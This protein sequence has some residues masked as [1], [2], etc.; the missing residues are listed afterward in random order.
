MA[1]PKSR[2]GCIVTHVIEGPTCEDAN[3]CFRLGIAYLATN[4]L[5][6]AKIG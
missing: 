4:A 5:G 6:I 3:G 1:P 2:L